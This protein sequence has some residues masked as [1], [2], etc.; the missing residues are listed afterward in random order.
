MHFAGECRAAMALY[1]QAFGTQTERRHMDGARMSH[2]VM[3]IRW[4]RE[5]RNDRFGNLA[6]LHGG[7]ARMMVMFDTPAELT[8]AMTYRRMAAQLSNR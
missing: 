1:R 5:L 6:R 3:N 8:P 4:Q 2:A 7:A